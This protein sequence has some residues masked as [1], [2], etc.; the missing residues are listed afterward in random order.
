MISKKVLILS[1]V[2]VI[3]AIMFSSCTVRRVGCPVN[4]THGFGPGR[5]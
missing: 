2:I 3:I 4:A 5:I 1:A